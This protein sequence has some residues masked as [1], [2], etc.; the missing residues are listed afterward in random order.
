MEM[1]SSDQ[2][3]TIRC[4]SPAAYLYDFLNYVYSRFG[5]DFLGKCPIAEPLVGISILS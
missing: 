3:L 4:F 1:F 5:T 2:R